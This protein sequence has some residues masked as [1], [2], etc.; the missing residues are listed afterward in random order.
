MSAKQR[1]YNE[2]MQFQQ[3]Q[4]QRAAYRN[5]LLSACD[6]MGFKRETEAHAKCVLSLHQQNVQRIDNA[7]LLQ[8]RSVQQRTP[9]YNTNCSTLGGY[10]NCTTQP[11]GGVF[12]DPNGPRFGY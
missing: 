5:R 12:G 11:S 10:T 3:E 6:S 1:A 9:T 7:A 8:Q 4:Q 2:Q